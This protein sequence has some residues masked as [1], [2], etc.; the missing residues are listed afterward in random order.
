M[1]TL[2]SVPPGR[3]LGEVKEMSIKRQARLGVKMI[4]VREHVCGWCERL[5]VVKVGNGIPNVL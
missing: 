4:Q 1:W 3:I 2:F 5:D